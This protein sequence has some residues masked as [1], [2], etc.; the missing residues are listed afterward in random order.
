MNELGNSPADK[1]Y[2]PSGI[3]KAEE[4]ALIRFPEQMTPLVYQELID[5]FGGKT[6]IDFNLLPRSYFQ[7]GYEQAEK[8]II[9]IIESR[10]SEIVG[11]AQPRPALRAE[12]EEL[13]NKLKEK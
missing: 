13:I 5:Q 8:D 10:I 11:D 12:L 3:S 4:Q 2:K 9:A 1:N 6:E 7:L